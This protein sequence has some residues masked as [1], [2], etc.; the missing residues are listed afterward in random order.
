LD[1]LITSFDRLAVCSQLSNGRRLPQGVR[2]IIYLFYSTLLAS[3]DWFLALV[4]DCVLVSL[5]VTVL[6]I[7]CWH[8]SASLSLALLLFLILLFWKAQSML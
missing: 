8:I 3:A 2:S 1:I 4:S 6:A 5:A 7:G